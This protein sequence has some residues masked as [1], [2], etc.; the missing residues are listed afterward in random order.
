[1]A[2]IATFRTTVLTS[3]P[4]MFSSVQQPHH[5]VGPTDRLPTMLG[6]VTAQEPIDGISVAIQGIV[7]TKKKRRSSKGGEK[8]KHSP[9]HHKTHRPYSSALP[10]LPT[11]SQTSP[12]YTPATSY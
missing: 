4:E 9:N 11:D 12:S 5:D 10:V 3:K 2:G 6:W 8:F 7:G 1:M